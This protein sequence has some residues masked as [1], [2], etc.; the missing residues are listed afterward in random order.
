MAQFP[1]SLCTPGTLQEVLRYSAQHR[2]VIAAQLR[3]EGLVDWP[4]NDPE[5]QAFYE[6][7]FRLL[8]DDAKRDRVF[9]ALHALAKERRKRKWRGVLYVPA[10]ILW[11]V[12]DDLGCLE[13]LVRDLEEARLEDA[14]AGLLERLRDQGAPDHQRAWVEWVGRVLREKGGEEGTETPDALRRAWHSRL[15][16]L[17]ADVQQAMHAEPS[18]EM[19]V[20]LGRHVEKLESLARH[21]EEIAH[22]TATMQALESMVPRLQAMDAPASDAARALMR[23]V[24]GEACPVMPP[25]ADLESWK[26][27]VEG[28]LAHGETE[29]DCRRRLEQAAQQAR[30]EEV[31]QLAEE[32]RHARDAW[33]EKARRLMRD[34]EAWM[35]AHAPRGEER[36]DAALEAA[37]ARQRETPEAGVQAQED[38]KP[39]PAAQETSDAAAVAE[40]TDVCDPDGI[41]ETDMSRDAGVRP[42]E[43]E[44]AEEEVSPEGEELGMSGSADEE[45]EEEPEPDADADPHLLAERVCTGEGE[46]RHRHA[47]L[48][49]WALAREDR[50][51][52]AVHLMQALAETTGA[53]RDR[54]MVGGLRAL[55]LAEGLTSPEDEEAQE[56]RKVV[57]ALY[58]DSLETL[59]WPEDRPL[60]LLLFAGLFWPALIAPYVS[61]APEALRMLPLGE[62]ALHALRQE[63]LQRGISFMELLAVE[64]EDHYLERMRGEAAEWWEANRRHTLKIPTA[65]AFWKKLLDAKWPV[66][67]ALEIVVKGDATRLDQ[68]R[69]LRKL[70]E[71]PE[72]LIHRLHREMYG[73][74]RPFVGDLLHDMTGRVR[75]VAGFLDRW[76]T[77]M[78]Q[79]RDSHQRSYLIQKRR[80]LEQLV[81]AARKEVEEA[82]AGART[83]PDRAAYA[84]VQRMLAQVEQRLES[85]ETPPKARWWHRLHGVLLPARDVCLKG[86]R[87]HPVFPDGAD[88]LAAIAEIVAPVDWQACFEQACACGDHEKAGQML[89][90]ARD[91]GAPQAMRARLE[92]WERVRS[93]SL[94]RWK[95]EIEGMLEQ[96]GS[97]IERAAIHGCLTDGE[98][99][100]LAARL[101][102]LA[103]QA[104]VSGNHRAAADGI[105]EVQAETRTFVERRRRELEQI[106]ESVQHAAKP[107]D[108]ARVRQLLAEDDMLTASDFL[109]RMRQGEEIPEAARDCDRGIEA[110]FPNFVRDMA[111]YLQ[112]GIHRRELLERLRAGRDVG[113]LRMQD[114]PEGVRESAA[115]MMEAWWEIRQVGETGAGRI[116][117]PLQRLFEALGFEVQALVRGDDRKGTTKW[118]DLQVIPVC[119]RDTCAVPDFGSRAEGRYRVLCIW[120][121]PS[122]EDL[123]A[124]SRSECGRGAVIALYFGLMGE[125]ERRDLAHLCRE[126]NQ[127]LLV[128]DEILMLFLCGE[129]RRRAR[130]FECTLPF[131]VA[132]PYVTSSGP[133]PPEMFFGRRGEIEEVVGVNGP[134]LVYGGRQL[135]KTALLHEAVRRHH[136]PREGVIVT[137]M[138]LKSRHIGIGRPPAEIWQVLDQELVRKRVLPEGRRRGT[139]RTMEAIEQWLE[140]DPRRRIVMLLDEADAFLEEDARQRYATVGEIKELMERTQRR[141]KVVFAG[142]HNVQRTSRDVNTPLAH[143]GTPI[144]V[145]PLLANGEAREAYQLVELPLR[146]LGYRF[147]SSSLVHSIL[148]QTNYYPNLIQIFCAELLKHLQDPAT[149][150]FGRDGPPFEIRRHHVERVFQHR[151][152]RRTVRERFQITLDLD[153]RYQVI[154]LVIALETRLRS[155]QGKDVSEGFDVDWVRRQALG[156]W[157]RGFP[158]T[159]L[160]AFHALLDEMVELGVLRH[161][162]SEG[163]RYALRSLSIANLLGTTG[164]IELALME[165]ASRDAPLRYEASSYRRAAS[166]RQ[167]HLRS[168][169]TS[170]QEA[171][172][173]EER[174]GVVV[175]LGLKVA[176][177]EE[178]PRFLE[179]MVAD[180][181]FVQLH[182]V[183]GC[184][185]P[186][187]FRRQLGKL[188]K[189]SGEGVQLILVS[190]DVPW[191]ARWVEDAAALLRRRRSFHQK[192]RVLFLG[193]GRRAWAW[194][195][196]DRQHKIPELHE[197]SLAPWTEGFV[198]HWANEADLGALGDSDLRRIR[199]RTGLWT[200]PMHDLARYLWDRREGWRKA[201]EEDLAG[202]LVGGDANLLEDLP[203]GVV[204]AL[205]ILAQYGD[206]IS[207]RDWAGLMEGEEGQGWDPQIVPWGMCVNAL[208]PGEDHRYRLDGFLARLLNEG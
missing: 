122:V 142:L 188:L 73:K 95:H 32:A 68:A 170:R 165:A 83:L 85:R 97:E 162:D 21:H 51:A 199:E 79:P 135:G 4:D 17:A 91:P 145:G 96:A 200:K 119:D 202:Y 148:A 77:I 86:D 156:W 169:L 101:E 129:R 117:Q 154:A 208:V 20:R 131:T 140:R 109:N 62:G 27:Q 35:E 126:R 120:G 30:Y 102:N 207:E 76:L 166:V 151:D 41:R 13:A 182:T 37:R 49:A 195:T 197:I 108:V 16:A 48:L 147:A 34:I 1:R 84:C 163:S 177:V 3:R 9:A 14:L 143:F 7:L 31:P 33:E 173:L 8:M 201:W 187:G 100:R 150:R 196:R 72:Q 116:R 105:R 70:L 71:D 25:L 26:A 80:R 184:A 111:G 178:V 92:G 40:E 66:G 171:E 28:I 144:C 98:R 19:V 152:L 186:E 141:F 138:D 99:A 190:H 78:E 112:S 24:E 164:E 133:M 121:E 175:L 94:S 193:D 59:A 124:V 81:Q 43:E 194:C 161:A 137:W 74:R 55:V 176:G 204:Q 12:A 179:R 42:A 158:E 172:I 57:E 113:P 174:D 123:L 53:A 22:R 168:P 45:A 52:L 69:R 127:S 75:T 93:R 18:L 50:A 134:N 104:K 181:G 65:T 198:K 106:L 88:R 153:N 44:A 155:E 185:N 115:R 146:Q 114:V 6:A 160:D 39:E 103:Q 191:D 189:G 67:E 38:G 46:R 29:R 125:E 60:A 206:P 107:Q 192:R 54:L 89:A 136:R 11:M 87:W 64:Q 110:F 90:W 203:G 167:P 82:C 23:L 5:E 180:K 10:R 183:R 15:E 63:A 58:E 130:L 128:V 157:E 118:F 132:R 61:Q 159:S 205:R 36:R 139:R 2:H 149:G 56:I 47:R